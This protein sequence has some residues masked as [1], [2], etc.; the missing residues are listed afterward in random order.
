MSCPNV[1]AVRVIKDRDQ[2]F[3]SMYLFDIIHALSVSMCLIPYCVHV[4]D[5]V[6]VYIHL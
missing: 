6:S 5:I 3:L 1:Y 4:I 2:M